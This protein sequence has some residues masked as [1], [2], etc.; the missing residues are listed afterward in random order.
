MT[1]RKRPRPLIEDYAEAAYLDHWAEERMAAEDAG[2]VGPPVRPW[3]RLSRAERKRWEASARRVIEVLAE[4]LQGLAQ[5][6]GPC[7]LERRR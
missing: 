2:K 4:D 3:S 1:K 7:W 6:V 5:T